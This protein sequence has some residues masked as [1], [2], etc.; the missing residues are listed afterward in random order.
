M[1][2]LKKH[3]LKLEND[4]L[5]PEIR[6]SVEKTSELLIDGFTEFTSSGYIY[7][8]NMGQV[9]DEGTNLQEMDWAITDFEINQ[10]SN[11]CVLATY[12]LTKNSESDENKKY[13]LR[14]SIWKCFDG[15]WKMIFHQGTLAK[16]FK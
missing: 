7:N 12:R 10:L 14:S 11:D 9:I 1:E 2:S 3:I 16:K 5:K 6:E 15:K 8:Y 13:S 4:L